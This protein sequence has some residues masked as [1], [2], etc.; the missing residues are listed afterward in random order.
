MPN[1]NIRDGLL[2]SELIDQ[3]SPEAERLLVRMILAGDDAGRITGRLDVLRSKC[4]PLK[5]GLPLEALAD[6]LRECE[7]VGAVLGYQFEGKAFIQIAKTQRYG[8]TEFS[9]C[10]WSDGSFQIHYVTRETKDGNKQFVSTSLF[11]GDLSAIAP[12]VAADGIATPSAPHSDGVRMGSDPIPEKKTSTSTST[13]NENEE[14]QEAPASGGIRKKPLLRPIPEDFGISASVRAWAEKN[15]HEQLETRFE[16]FVGWA[17][18][19]DSR[20]ANWDQAFM[21]AIRDDWAKLN[22][23]RSAALATRW[24]DPVF[25][26]PEELGLGPLPTSQSLNQSSTP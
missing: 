25:R 26:T 3:L 21:N 9:K 16:Q 14:R 22:G 17:K 1:R 11:S 6:W 23:G 19:R 12:A 10:P 2:D 7:A 15:G 4:F 20:Y 18:S 13:R 8:K 5:P 24:P